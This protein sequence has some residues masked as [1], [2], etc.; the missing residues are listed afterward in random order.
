MSRARSLSPPAGALV[1]LAPAV[2]VLLIAVGLSP[3]LPALASVLP[4]LGPLATVA[5]GWFGFQCHRDPGRAL[6]V[7]G[8]ALPVCARCFGIYAGLGC[9]ALLLRPRLEG[10]F[11]RV[12][13]VASVLVMLL[14]VVTE[15]LEM[16]PPS[17]AA[18]VITGA[19]LAWPIGV[20]LVQNARR[21]ARGSDD[22]GA[23][24]SPPA[25]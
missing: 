23:A 17:A 4:A 9:G 8:V 25:Q 18:R 11:I 24:A 3:W 15:L 6:A 2:R 1:W 13:I 20:A 21:Y 10:R 14:D 5:E 12:W 7:G 16:R 19:L 22:H